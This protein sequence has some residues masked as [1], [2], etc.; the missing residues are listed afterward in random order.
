MAWTDVEIAVGAKQLRRL[1]DKVDRI[2]NL[3]SAAWGRA[4]SV[5]VG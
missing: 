4:K 1:Q 5:A 2:I 3:G